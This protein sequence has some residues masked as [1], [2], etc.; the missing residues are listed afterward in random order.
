MSAPASGLIATIAISRITTSDDSP[1][2]GRTIRIT[3]AAGAVDKKILL[4]K[5]AIPDRPGFSG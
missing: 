4:G 3:A 1:P 5:W 2:I